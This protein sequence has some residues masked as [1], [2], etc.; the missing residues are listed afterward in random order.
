MPGSG[1]FSPALR[2]TTDTLPGREASFLASEHIAVKRLGA[3]Y[4]AGG[5]TA[6]AAGD[7]IL[8]AGTLVGKVTATGKYRPYNDAGSGGVETAAGIVMETLN[9]RDGDVIAGLML[10]G[11]VLEARC[12]GVNAAAKVDLAGRI[13][14][15]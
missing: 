7:K 14:F 13:W 11:S 9:L 1:G 12:T 8:K 6:N 5:V 15:Q 10:H 4:D 2:R 3:T